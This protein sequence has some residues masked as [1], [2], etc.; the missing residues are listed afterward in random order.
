MGAFDTE[1]LC[2]LQEIADK[3]Q[4]GLDDK[5]THRF[6]GDLRKESGN[7]FAVDRPVQP[8]EPLQ[9]LGITG[10]DSRVIIVVPN[11][12]E[13]LLSGIISS[14][15]GVAQ[16]LTW[17][18][19]TNIVFPGGP[20]WATANPGLPG[21]LFRYVHQAT[22]PPAVIDYRPSGLL[23]PSGSRIAVQAGAAGVTV[24]GTLLINRR[25]T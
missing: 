7:V 12:E 25:Q 8:I 17:F 2:L 14:S 18:F 15:T 24:L 5:P 4:R 21:T 3:L 1:Q 20:A 11:N 16:I 13:W 9:I 10:A 6:V 19:T 23:I 22:S